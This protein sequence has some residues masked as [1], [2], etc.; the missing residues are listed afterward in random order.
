M[1]GDTVTPGRELLAL[2]DTYVLAGV[3]CATISP[4]TQATVTIG[5]VSYTGNGEAILK[6]A[7]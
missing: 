6:L 2:V 4:E 7:R 1:D 5:D 3:W